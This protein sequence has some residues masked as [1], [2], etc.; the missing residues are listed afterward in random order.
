MSYNPRHRLPKTARFTDR[1][2]VSLGKKAGMSAASAVLAAGGVTV[3]FAPAALAGTGPTYS[4]AFGYQFASNTGGAGISGSSDTY[5][6]V[7]NSPLSYPTSSQSLGSAGV[8]V[9]A[10]PAAVTGRTYADSGVIVDLGTVANNEDGSGNLKVPTVTDSSGAAVNINIYFDTNGDGKYFKFNSDGVYEGGAYTGSETNPSSSSVPAG[11]DTVLDDVNAPASG[12]SSPTTTVPAAAVAAYE[13]PTQG[14]QTE[15]WAWV[16]VDSS[17]GKVSATFASVDGKSLVTA[18][19]PAPTYPVVQE[20]TAVPSGYNLDVTGQVAAAGT[21]IVEWQAAWWDPAQDFSQLSGASGTQLAYTPF[22]SL[23]AAESQPAGY[24]RDQAVAAYNADGTVKYC[25]A[26]SAVPGGDALLQPCA[27]DGTYFQLTSGSDPGHDLLTTGSLA[28]N[29][30]AFGRDGSWVISWPTDNQQ[31][32]QF[33]A[34][35]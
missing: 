23:A 21:R 7:A 11:S 19:P 34:A 13:N 18:T 12:S 35:S 26:A 33:Y 6:R 2:G 25:V 14:A 29:D 30:A 9:T 17:G 27:T 5:W 4:P 22:G 24:E 32:E 8:T 3:A 15:V 31:N 28:L 16:G 1:H 20:Q 10:F